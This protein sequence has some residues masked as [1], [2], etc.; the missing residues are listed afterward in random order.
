MVNRE[1]PIVSAW[2][3][4]PARMSI[5]PVLILVALFG[6][7]GCGEE[8]PT[9]RP[10]IE[11]IRT[12]IDESGTTY[13]NVEYGFWISNL[14]VSGCVIDTRKHKGE[15]M[16]LVL[17][18]AFTAEDEFT[19]EEVDL[20]KEVP[21]LQTE[22]IPYAAVGVLGLISDLPTKPDLAKE[23]MDNVISI[24]ELWFEVLS[25]RPVAGINTTGY[26]VTVSTFSMYAPGTTWMMKQAFFAKHEMG[27]TIIFCAPEDKFMGLLAYIDP[28]IAGFQLIGR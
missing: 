27:Y 25:E 5:A 7:M 23:L 13:L 20:T 3:E 1:D 12:G 10:E 8:L 16:E 18:M 26:E 17:R 11:P 15:D 28:M 14:P 2:M 21:R 22:G 19:F 4:E 9:N 6:I 24:Y